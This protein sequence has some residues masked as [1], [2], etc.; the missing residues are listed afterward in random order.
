MT[1]PHPGATRAPP[2]GSARRLP[3]PSGSASRP[4][5]LSDDWYVLKQTTFHWRRRDGSWQRQSRET[6]D[7]GNGTR[8]ILLYDRAPYW[9]L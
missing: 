3:D 7:R 1:D 5:L 8:M 4:A 9:L 2:G 6:Y